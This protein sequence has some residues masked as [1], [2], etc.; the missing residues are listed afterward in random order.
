MGATDFFHCFPSKRSKLSS[1]SASPVRNVYSHLDAKV[2]NLSNYS[3]QSC[4]FSYFILS[5][6]PVKKT[7]SR[8]YLVEVGEPLNEGTCSFLSY[9]CLAFPREIFLRY[10]PPCSR[11]L[12][13]RLVMGRKRAQVKPA[14]ISEVILEL[15]S[16]L[17]LL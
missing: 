5:F 13:G 12:Q 2:R 17:A 7:C 11:T 10:F 16:E 1:N 8:A 3:T 6:S 4:G 9:L 15:C 14:F